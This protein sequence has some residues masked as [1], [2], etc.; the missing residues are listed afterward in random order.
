MKKNGNMNI[1]LNEIR[2]IFN[3]LIN[4]IISREDAAKW[5]QI[6]QQAEDAGQLEYEPPQEED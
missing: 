5:A 2:M 6:R 4:E 3:N 1:T